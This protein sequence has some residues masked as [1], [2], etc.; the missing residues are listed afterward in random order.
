MQSTFNPERPRAVDD[1]GRTLSVQSDSLDMVMADAIYG[2]M[3]SHDEFRLYMQDCVHLGSDG[4]ENTL[5]KRV[6]DAVKR[7]KDK[8]EEPC[9]R[10]QSGHSI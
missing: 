6:D 8:N 1:D 10:D 2:R 7:R 3:L 4:Q 5:F 9:C